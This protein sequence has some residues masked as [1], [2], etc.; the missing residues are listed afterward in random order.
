MHHLNKSIIMIT[1]R[2]G[3]GSQTG[4]GKNMKAALLIMAA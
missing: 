2:G 3:H 4:R 1:L